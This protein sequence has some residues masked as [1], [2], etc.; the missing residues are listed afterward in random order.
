[1]ESSELAGAR[2]RKA[3]RIPLHRTVAGFIRNPLQTFEQIGRQ[4]GGEAVRL[5]L[6]VSRPYLVSRAEDMQHVLRDRAD[7][8][9]RD[10]MMWKPL[11]RMFGDGLGMEGPGWERSRK[12]IMPV[13]AAKN[14]ATTMGELTGALHEGIDELDPYAASGEPFDAR[15]EMTRVIHR[16]LIRVFIGSDMST[17]DADRL[18][19][20]IT[21]AF[22][23][24]GARLLMPFVPESVPLPGDA[25]FMRAT[26]VADSIVS[27]LVRQ[28]RRDGATGNDMVSML[29]R[30]RDEDGNELDDE[31]VRNDVVAMFAG[32]SETSAVTMTWLWV[33]L[34]ANP[35]IAKRLYEEIDQVIGHERA[36]PEHL[37]RLVYTKMVLQELL[38]LYPVAWIIPRHIRADDVIGSVR[39]KGGN[40]LLASP[41]LLHRSPDY[42]D[43]PDVFDPERFSPQRA[44]RR[45]AS[46]YLPFGL[47]PHQCLG[48]HFFTIEAQLMMAILLS[49]YRP[50]LV[51]A[52]PVRPQA[53]ATLR[54]RYPVQL[55]LR[56]GRY[57][58]PQ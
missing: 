35:E 2:A 8:Y 45:Q 31:L 46:T 57:K 9:V 10:G 16:A 44:Q 49:R 6:G 18:G 37:P 7:N 40:T 41:Y 54:P 3:R 55:I 36:G 53:A 48:S 19:H 25:A 32:A 20:A 1:M 21:G 11:R 23:S 33:A 30:A 50:E 12:L 15:L 52:R 29:C 51:G 17:A 26:R 34:D 27:P 4:Y 56:G 42:W 47:G 39:V 28:R 58:V 14:V 24:I 38:R 22:T 43:Q 13:F 5:D